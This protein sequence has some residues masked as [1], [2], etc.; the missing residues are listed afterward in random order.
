MTSR[1]KRLMPLQFASS[2]VY[3]NPIHHDRRFVALETFDDMFSSMLSVDPEH[4]GNLHHVRYLKVRQNEGAPGSEYCDRA[5][6]VFLG[7]HL[8]IVK[9]PCG[10]TL[11]DLQETL[12][13]R[14]FTLPVAKRI[15]KQ[16]LLALDFLHTTMQRTHV[17]SSLVFL[18]LVSL[19]RVAPEVDAH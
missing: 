9:E 4:N 10:P 14:S 8:C 18:Y 17:G 1:R 12:P 15:I 5:L 13:H 7:P 16:T 2:C 11:A 19:V 6:R 3:R